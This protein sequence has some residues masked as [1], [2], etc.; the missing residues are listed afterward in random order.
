ME[1][2]LYFLGENKDSLTTVG[3]I[4]TLVVSIVSLYFSVK[5][6]K[7]VHYVNSVTKNRSEWI[8]CLRDKISKFIS[9]VNIENT[10]F[11]ITDSESDMERSGKHLALTKE[12]CENIKL[13]MNFTDER[14]RKIIQ[15]LEEIMTA[16][17]T[18][19]HEAMD[20]K[21]EGSFFYETAEMECQ[22]KIIEEKIPELTKLVQIYLKSEWNRV[23]EESK[24]KIYEKETKEFDIIELEKKFENPEYQ[25]DLF[26]RSLIDT[27]ARI[28]RILQTYFGAIVILLLATIIL[29]II[30]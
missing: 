13:M 27:R 18:Y 20:C 8:Y 7:A 14:D 22:S 10:S 3:V 11:Y 17:S 12:L 9:M 5:N 26:R 21:Q 15:L 19:Y 28:K 16:F 2:V 6:N 1:K 30:A 25:N 29:F 23:K 4:M 24:G